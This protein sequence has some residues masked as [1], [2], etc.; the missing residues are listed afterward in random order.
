METEHEENQ[1]QEQQRRSGRLEKRGGVQQA[2]IIMPNNLF[3]DYPLDNDGDNY[4]TGAKAA[5]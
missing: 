2:N 5:Y 4:D 3:F 1:I